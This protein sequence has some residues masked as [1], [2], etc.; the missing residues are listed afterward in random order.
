MGFFE[1]MRGY[2][3]EVDIDFSLSLIPLTGTHVIVVVKGLYVELTPEVIGR[4]TIIP[5]RFPWRKEDKRNIKIAK[6]KLFLGGEEVTKDKNEVKRERL[7]YAWNET[8]YHLTNYMSF[9]GRY[10][11]VY[12]YH[13]MLP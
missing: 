12:G 7:P 2:D 8:S 6:K 10:N 11:V 13:L 9:G 4:I 1:E 5:F 3:D